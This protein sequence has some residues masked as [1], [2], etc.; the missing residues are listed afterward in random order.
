MRT[1]TF[2]GTGNAMPKRSATTSFLLNENGNKLLIDCA[3]GHEI[4]GRLEQSGTR[5]IE[6]TDIFISHSDSDHILGIV[7]VMRVIKKMDHP[8]NL[9]CSKE[10]YA[11][12]ESL[13]AIVGR[14]HW[15]LAQPNLN[16]I[17]VGDGTVLEH[18][19]WTLRFIETGTKVPMH[20]LLVTFNDGFRMFY[21]GDEPLRE[22]HFS[23]ADGV[24]LLLHEAFCLNADES[25][26]EAR[27]KT[28][29]TV[30][31]AAGIASSVHA[32]H[33]ALIHMEDD[34][35][36]SRKREYAK[37]ASRYFTGTI[38]VPVDLDILEF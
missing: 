37:E 38:T 34:T 21:P 25:R 3:G 36:E 19:G 16:W 18:N 15:E 1:L 6:L 8:C 33:L 27:K 22:P 7:P 13:F 30:A 29:S 20:G 2:L 24:D 11:A 26:Y 28:H 23:T 35:L 12:V 4:V 10:T 31:D 32:K 5:L 17:E 14:K 9:I